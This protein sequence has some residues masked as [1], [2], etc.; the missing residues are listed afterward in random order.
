MGLNSLVWK[1]ASPYDAY[2]SH[3]GKLQGAIERIRYFSDVALGYEAG[4]QSSVRLVPGGG[5]PAAR[6]QRFREQ[7]SAAA[8]KMSDEEFE[9]FVA[10]LGGG[11]VAEVEADRAK[12]VSRLSHTTRGL[13]E[14]FSIAGQEL[15]LLER[16]S[17]NPHRP[18]IA[19]MLRENGLPGTGL[20]ELRHAL[21]ELGARVGN[22]AA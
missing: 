19:R 2:V 8:E 7:L 16:R 6:V 13:A 9:Q 1:L 12:A 17:Y 18:D 20:A 11:T 10:D 4:L 3:V 15:T 21:H 14:Y 5:D 22:K